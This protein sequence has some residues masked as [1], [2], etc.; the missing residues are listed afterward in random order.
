MKKILIITQKVDKD[1]P[2]LGFMHRWIEEFAEQVERVEVICLWEGKHDFG[3]E[4]YDPRCNVPFRNVVVRSL[5]KNRGFSK[6]RQLVRFWK[7][8]LEIRDIDGAFV[9]MNAVYV[10]LG[11]LIW[12]MHG[13]KIFL[14]RNHP[15]G[16]LLAKVAYGL[17]DR[18]FFTSPYAHAAGNDKAEQMPAG[19]DTRRFRP[20]PSIVK[21]PGSILMLGRIAP[22]KRLEKVIAAAN[23]LNGSGIPFTLDIVGDAEKVDSAY[24]RGIHKAT[25]ALLEK[26]RIVFRPSIKNSDAPQCYAEHE[27]Y[28]NATLTGSYDKTVL[29]AM[30]CGSLPLV[31]N[32]SFKDVL[33]PEFLF[34]EN[35]P[36]ELAA[37]IKNALAL[38][39]KERENLANQLGSYVVKKHGLDILIKLVLECYDR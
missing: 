33:P 23:I 31:A 1:D 17:A 19:I 4:T 16:S 10:P 6:L 30:A 39:P 14:W 7:F 28:I 34:Q 9:H 13:K 35:D 27:L 26:G 22:V 15:E 12:R 2:V 3:R 11:W 20:N 24:V 25:A 5:G 21:K 32:R 8:C 38:A 18:I 36:E 29:E 37:K